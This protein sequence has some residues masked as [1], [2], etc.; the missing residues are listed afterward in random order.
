ME[1]FIVNISGQGVRR[2]TENARKFLVAPATIL[3]ADQVLNGSKGK[4]FYS[5]NECGRNPGAWNKVPL[6]LNHPVDAN[7]RPDRARLPDGTLNR[8]VIEK[9]GLGE[10]RNDNWD[11]KHRNVEAW[12]DEEATRN[13]APDVYAALNKNQSI[14]LS[15]G[16]F[17]EDRPVANGTSPQGDYY[18]HEV[19]DHTPDHLAILP[20]QVGACSRQMGCGVNNAESCPVAATYNR[21]WPQSKRDAAP[22]GDFAGPDQSFPISA[23]TDVDAAAHLV[24]KAADPA[25]VKSK[26]KAIAK[27]KGLKVPDAWAEPTGN[28]VSR[29]LGKI[30]EKL[31]IVVDNADKKLTENDDDEDDMTNN[32]WGSDAKDAATDAQKASCSADTMSKTA[33][34]KKGGPSSQAKEAGKSAATVDQHKEA[35]FMHRQA[36][37]VHSMIAEH[38]SDGKDAH[39][40]AMD[41]HTQAAAAHDKAARLKATTYNQSSTERDAMP[42][43]KAETVKDLTTNCD[44]WKGKDKTLNAFDDDTLA[45]IAKQYAKGK[46][47]EATANAVLKIARDN[48]APAE[49]TINSL[50]DYIRNK[51]QAG[52]S[53]LEEDA[54]EAETASKN[55]AK[56]KENPNF[57]T[58]KTEN[59]FTPDQQELLDTARSITENAKKAL[60]DR[61]ITA[62]IAASE[63]G[64]SPSAIA[65]DVQKYTA[66]P[67][68][69]LVESAAKLPAPRRTTTNAESE[70]DT[71]LDY[72]GAGGFTGNAGRGDPY[73]DGGLS[74]TDILE[75][76]VNLANYQGKIFDGNEGKAK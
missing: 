7:G 72:S 1:S 67:Y 35:S 73:Y 76:T 58:S 43:N 48:G 29:I 27:R 46:A 59:Q 16:L 42:F 40:G 23:Q 62:N 12:F 32:M 14:E 20:D 45:I 11:G 18:S 30:A 2:V 75:P 63:G 49:L 51:V 54:S 55:P 31:G 34:V 57:P 70:F 47:A 13:K 9:T 38:I 53:S 64:M 4:L 5:A 28:A 52:D 66:M 44:C 3:V 39:K 19:V 41:A 74:D 33:G 60:V 68:K 25:A 61:I 22:S 65:A 24:G 8:A 6:V 10:V 71:I 15:T 50:P 36:A 26:I 21:N 69:K 17:T 37:N 56:K